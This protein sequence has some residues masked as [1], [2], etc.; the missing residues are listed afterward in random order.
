[1]G[2]TARLN[3]MNSNYDFRIM[4]ILRKRLSLTLELLAQ[5]SRLTYATV[6]AV[7][8]NKAHPSLKT[9]DALANALQ[10]STSQ[11][12]GLAEQ[13]SI[14]RRKALMLTNIA[15]CRL[16]QFGNAKIIHIS[17][18]AGEK[19]AAMDQHDDVHEICYVTRGVVNLYIGKKV[20]R[21]EQH[22]TL[23]F[24]GMLNH[25]YRQIEKGDVIIIHIPKDATILERLLSQNDTL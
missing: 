11:L 13:R 4:R 23:L 21:L 8:N 18:Q 6:A 14:L 17:A 12:L 1:M 7:E 24:N 16:A 20:Y 22:D 3:T 19:I 5:Q 25:Y 10:I 15:C 9:L 2:T